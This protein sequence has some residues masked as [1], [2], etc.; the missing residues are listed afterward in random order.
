MKQV[1][2]SSSSKALI[3]SWALVCGLGVS[4]SS[5]QSDE[6]NLDVAVEETAT[7][8]AVEGQEAYADN[9]IALAG[10]EDNVTNNN[11]TVGVDPGSENQM[12]EEN[13]NTELPTEGNMAEA[14]EAGDSI[15]NIA[16]SGEGN[17][18][19]EA[20]ADPDLTADQSQEAIENVINDSNTALPADNQFPMA[21]ETVGGNEINETAGDLP[22]ADAMSTGAMADAEMGGAEAAMGET[23]MGGA[24]AAMPPPAA[25]EGSSLPEM[26]AKLTY[27]VKK[28]DTLGDIAQNIYGDKSRWRDLARWSGFSNPHLIFPGNLVYYQYTEQSAAFAQQYENQPKSEVVVQAGDS[29]SGIAERVYGD[30]THWVIIWRHNGHVTN[31]DRIEVGQVITYPQQGYLS[32]EQDTSKV[33]NDSSTETEA[34]IVDQDEQAAE[35]ATTQEVTQQIKQPLPSTVVAEQEAA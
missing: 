28:G 15:A 8:N 10:G 26:G 2:F 25:V 3:A 27:V 13:A 19:A 34:E 18:L 9:Q 20:G 12:M 30:P 14:N 33:G 24:E 16:E 22:A 21:N 31:P 17:V 32:V 7:G 1:A 5:S 6:E 11:L 35:Q 4:C 29:L 23:E